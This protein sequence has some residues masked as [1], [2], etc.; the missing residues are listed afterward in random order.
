MSF[1]LYA[2]CMSFRKIPLNFMSTGTYLDFPT[3]IRFK[4]L[5]L[6]HI[7]IQTPGELLVCCGLKSS[8]LAC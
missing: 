1:F 5:F 3:V 4:K 7:D 8:V 2:K 6:L